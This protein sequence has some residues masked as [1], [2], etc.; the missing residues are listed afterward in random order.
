MPTTFTIYQLSHTTENHTIAIFLLR[1]HQHFSII[2]SI[3]SGIRI[4]DWTFHNFIENLFSKRLEQ[5]FCLD[6][7]HGTIKGSVFLTFQ[8]LSGEV[9][10]EGRD[11]AGERVTPF[12]MIFTAG[13]TITGSDNLNKCKIRFILA[14]CYKC[15]KYYN[16]W[17]TISDCFNI[18]SSAASDKWVTMFGCWHRV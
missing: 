16:E 7:I 5:R 13:D 1:H 8:Y 15:G 10:R 14:S 2:I 4:F 17:E 9:S 6:L 3:I 11:I 18:V 12:I